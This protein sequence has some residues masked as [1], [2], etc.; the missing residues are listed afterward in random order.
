MNAR[1]L[2]VDDE[3]PILDLV[4]GYLDREGYEV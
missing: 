3:T 2:L 1:I 4:R